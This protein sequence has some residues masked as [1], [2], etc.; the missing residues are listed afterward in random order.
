MTM[1]GITA[2]SAALK[3]GNMCN[4]ANLGFRKEAFEQVGGYTGIDHIASG[5]DMLLMHKIYQLDPKRI[6]YLKS[7]EAIVQTSIQPSWKDFFNQRIRWSSKADQYKDIKLTIILL[8][9]YLFNLSIF[10]L[11]LTCLFVPYIWSTLGMVLFVKVY[12]ELLFLFSAAQFY[13]KIKELLVFPF[14]QPIH[15][16]YILIAGF[17]GKFGQYEWK[18]R[19]VK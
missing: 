9:V 11:F 14:L 18:G 1:Q 8:L 7:I 10:L 3:L 15:I 6:H 19:K 17:L 5:D 4:G 2:A 13:G 12:I 16:L